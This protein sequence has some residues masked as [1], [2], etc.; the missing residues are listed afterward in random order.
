MVDPVH[1]KR[2]A[3]GCERD[4]FHA[5]SARLVPFH[6]RRPAGFSVVVQPFFNPV[7]GMAMNRDDRSIAG[8][9]DRVYERNFHLQTIL[10]RASMQHL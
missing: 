7:R 1:V 5:E 3:S 4:E 2:A 6:T 9:D 10:K 8:R